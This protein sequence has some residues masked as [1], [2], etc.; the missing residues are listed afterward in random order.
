VCNNARYKILQVCGDVLGLPGISSAASPGLTLDSPPVDFVGL[1]RS[2]GVEAHRVTD[3]D[4][5][6]DRVRA[7]LAGL[8]P[9]LFDVPV[10]D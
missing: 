2:F 10:S 4:D 7:S 8:H 3:P 1:A 5:L 9:I 6:A